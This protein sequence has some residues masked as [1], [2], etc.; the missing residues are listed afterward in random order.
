MAKKIG[1][2]LG[3]SLVVAVLWFAGLEA[4]YARVLVG[5][6]NFVL[7]VAGSETTISL[8]QEGGE[9]AFQVRTLIEGQWGVYPQRLQTLLLPTVMVFA[10]QL[11]TA[12]YLKRKRALSSSGINIGL[13]FFF[14]L[15]FL[16]LLTDYHTSRTAHFFYTI[17]MDSFYIIGLLIIIIDNIRNP[18][19]LSSKR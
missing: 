16:M 4:I 2:L 15:V 14:H 3:A 11:F 12:F 7:G 18:I 17:F 10:W 13:F 5:F 19:F 6:A 9:R 1:I 8:T